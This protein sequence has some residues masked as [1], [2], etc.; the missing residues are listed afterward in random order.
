MTEFDLTVALLVGVG[1]GFTCGFGVGWAVRGVV[2]IW[3][4]R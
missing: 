3:V 4:R 2:E 1:L